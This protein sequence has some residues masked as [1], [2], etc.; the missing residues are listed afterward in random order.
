MEEPGNQM[1]ARSGLPRRWLAWLLLGVL[2][3]FFA[4][5]TSASSPLI[6]F[7]LFGLLVTLPLYTLHLLVLAPLVIRRGI[8]PSF[9]TL[10]LAGAIFGLYEGYITKVLWSPTWNPEAWRIGGMA[11]LETIVLVLCWYPFMAFILPLLTGSRLF[12]DPYTLPLHLNLPHIRWQ[13]W[14]KQG[15]EPASEAISMANKGSAIQWVRLHFKPAWLAAP[16]AILG[17]L[18]GAALGNPGTSL[19]SSVSSTLIVL[20]L[21]R[22]WQTYGR[23]KGLKLVDLLP[24]RREW[25]TFALLLLVDYL[26]LGLVLRRDMLP[27][28]PGQLTLWLLYLLFG[29]LLWFSRRA[30]QRRAMERPMIDQNAS[31]DLKVPSLQGWAWFGLGFIVLSVLA[32]LLLSWAG[33]AIYL[34]VW[35]AAV[36]I[37]LYSL[38]RSILNLN[39]IRGK[40]DDR[41]NPGSH[42]VHPA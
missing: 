26:V 10:L 17:I 41:K 5:V 32:S 15:K 30:D 40:N 24:N 31:L 33:S 37:G 18:H 8:R 25:R 12:G 39:P 11:V 1:K 2:S 16:G 20:L 22:L 29:G 6:F 14:R 7:D 9:G 23:G 38:G 13:F 34:L 42:P 36:P 4:E 35:V 3:V 27:G 21:A 19:L 28:L